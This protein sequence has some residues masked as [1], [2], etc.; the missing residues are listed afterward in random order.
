MSEKKEAIATLEHLRRI[1]TAP[2]ES[3]STLAK[4]DHAISENLTGFLQNNIVATDKGL[5]DIEKDFSDSKIPDTPMFVSQQAQFLLDKL[6]AQ[7]VHTASPRFIGHMTSAIPYFM[8]SLSKIM[9]ALNQNL[10]KTETSKAF[11]PLERQVLGMLHHLIY[12]KSD[13]FYN[14]CMHSS[15]QALGAFCS[16]GTIANITALW[17]ARNR[18]FSA[19]GNF[20][21]VAAEGMYRALK[22]YGY[23]G[24]AILVSRLGHYSL[25]KSADVLGIGR[26]EVVSVE[27]DDQH[28]MD[29]DALKQTCRQLTARRIKI[30]AIVGVAGTTEIGSVDPLHEIAVVANQL[31]TH[32]HVDAAWGGPTLFSQTY[33]QKLSGIELA[34]S[35]TL[36]AHKQLYVPIGAGMVVFKDPAALKSIEHHARYIIREGSKD[37]GSRTLEGSRPGVAMLVQ[38][39]LKVFGRQGYELLI[40]EGIKKSRYFAELIEMS[41]DF[42]LVTSP[43]L[44]ILTYRYISPTLKDGFGDLSNDICV[45]VNERLNKITRYIQK[46]QRERGNSFVSRTRVSIQKYNNPLVVF[47][48]VLANPLTTKQDL[49]MVLNEQRKIADEGLVQHHFSAIDKLISSSEEVKFQMGL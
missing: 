39:G 13:H 31:G 16:G 36:D 27:V 33:G 25:S 44:N 18:A 2:E 4:I 22:H 42:E 29:I 23:E 45:K 30:M 32:F 38:S 17:V 43:E 14:D 48:V 41:K 1:F 6:V 19:N 26:D 20:K 37:L 28:R 35:V 10:V 5:Y 40:D 47:R 21:G 8:L 7:S 15:N 9:I 49:E 24:S 3:D 11:T 34:D 46:N 12:A